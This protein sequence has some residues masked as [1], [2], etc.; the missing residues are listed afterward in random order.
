MV[1]KVLRMF[2]K[3]ELQEIPPLVYQLLLLSAKVRAHVSLPLSMYHEKKKMYRL[4]C[5]LDFG[6]NSDC[7]K[8]CCEEQDAAGHQ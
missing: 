6:R 1:E 8:L 3:L 5:R 2:S 7:S 4:S